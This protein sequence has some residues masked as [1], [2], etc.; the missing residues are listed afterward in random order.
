MK[1]HSLAIALLTIFSLHAQEPPAD[2][3]RE[4]KSGPDGKPDTT[5]KNASICYET[6]SLPLAMAAKLQ[7]DSPGDGD[8]YSRIVAAVEKNTARQETFTVIRCMSG[9]KVVSESLSEQMSP[10]E[11]E[12]PELPNSVGVALSPP[13]AKDAATPVPDAEKL[14]NAPALSSFEGIQTPATPTT[15]TVRKT[16]VTL[17]AELTLSENQDIAQLMLMPSHIAFAG[18]TAW[19]QGLA[20]SEFP[21]FETQNFA[22][23][24][25]LRFNQPFLFGTINRPPNSKLDPDSANRVWFAFVTITLAKP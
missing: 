22:T 15:I 18:R 7:R 17:Q 9:H 19:G 1:L 20:T 2:P 11:Y 3:F 23:S 4:T 6:F 8:L 12:P 13:Q 21:V 14:N 16:G 24:T 25:T 5:P 10:G